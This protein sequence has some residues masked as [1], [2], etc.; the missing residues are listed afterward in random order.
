MK[1]AFNL[2]ETWRWLLGILAFFVVI[3]VRGITGGNMW[4]CIGGGVIA[5][6]GLWWVIRVN[7][8]KTYPHILDALDAKFGLKPPTE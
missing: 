8:K 5:L 4:A 7:G 3:E 2:K 1:I 6:L